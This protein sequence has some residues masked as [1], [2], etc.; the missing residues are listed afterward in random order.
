MTFR[1]NNAMA[2]ETTIAPK[3]TWQK[4]LIYWHTKNHSTKA[5]DIATILAV[6][7]FTNKKIYEEELS[8]A[9]KL[10]HQQTN[11]PVAVDEL[12]EFIEMRLSEYQETVDAWHED[13]QKVR[14]LIEAN[15]ELYAHLRTIFEADESIDSEESDFEASLKKTLLRS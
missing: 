2:H 4:L 1:Y 6:A 11:D 5:Y 14:M 8:E 10:L 3:K 9:R 7:I 13:Q 15:Q 12:M